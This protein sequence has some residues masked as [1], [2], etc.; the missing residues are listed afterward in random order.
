MNIGDLGGERMEIVLG[1][2]S[3]R[4]GLRGSVV[5]EIFHFGEIHV[6]MRER[7]FWVCASCLPPNSEK[8]R[9]FVFNAI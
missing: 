8:D 6:S 5:R 3:V 1:L 9:S 2:V 7:N 4:A